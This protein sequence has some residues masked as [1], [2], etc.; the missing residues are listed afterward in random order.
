MW[1]T[2]TDQQ[3]GELLQQ[4][5]PLLMSNYD[6]WY[7]DCGFSA[8]VGAGHNWCS[9]YKSWQTAYDNSPRAIA[10]SFEGASGADYTAQIRGG[11]AALWSEQSDA[12]TLDS[13]LWPRAAAV[14]ERLWAEPQ[15][16]SAAALTRLVH[17]RER[18]VQRG[19]GAESLQPEYCHQNDGACVL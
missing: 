18:M 17:H 6:A 14:A 1:T 4:G 5:Y 16:D 7:L 3:I 2:G 9:P 11:A 19:V 15:T 12:Q 8:W 10:R 13:R